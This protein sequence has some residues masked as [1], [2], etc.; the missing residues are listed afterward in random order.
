MYIPRT[1]SDTVFPTLLNYATAGE[2]EARSGF[3]QFI[4]NS[5]S[6]IG[7]TCDD[8]HR[9]R[10]I[11]QI[12]WSCIGVIVACTWVAVHPNL[13]G[14]NEGSTEILWRRLKLMLITLIAPEILVVWA[15]RQWYA[16]R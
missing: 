16:A 11:F 10:T 13:P 3:T 2:L 9:C 15:S 14:P 7:D 12:L 1:T 6:A 8:I 5:T 4:D